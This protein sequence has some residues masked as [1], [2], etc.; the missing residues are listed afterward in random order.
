[1]IADRAAATTVM[2]AATLIDRIDQVPRDDVWV[3]AFRLSRLRPPG[4]AKSLH[5]VALGT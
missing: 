5:F 2:I 4:Q 3:A 1:M